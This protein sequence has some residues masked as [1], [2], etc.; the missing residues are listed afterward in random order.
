[1]FRHSAGEICFWSGKRR[2]NKENKKLHRVY[3]LEKGDAGGKKHP[4]TA[5]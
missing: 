2:M 1:M 5:V 3:I 4:S